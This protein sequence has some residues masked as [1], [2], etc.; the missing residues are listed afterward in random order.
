MLDALADVLGDF[1][2][3][4]ARQNG[5]MKSVSDQD[6]EKSGYMLASL[7]RGAFQHDRLDWEM[8]SVSV[9]A[10]LHALV[11]LDQNRRYRKGDF[12][13]FHHAASATG[14]CDL[15]LTES[16][17]RHLVYTRDFDCEGRFGCTVLSDEQTV[18][19]YLR[20]LE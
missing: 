4:H 17:L 1:M 18:I 19:E 20:T 14:Y 3:F 2:V 15:F 10:R 13:D 6:K 9:P 11:R 8:P 7:I 16:S 5:I 12:E